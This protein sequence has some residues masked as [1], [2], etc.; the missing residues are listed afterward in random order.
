MTSTTLYKIGFMV[1]FCTLAPLVASAQPTPAPT[2]PFQPNGI[3]GCNQTSAY[4]MSVGT[5]SAIGGTYVPVNDA[6]V[7]LNTGY[8]VYKE[9]V[10]HG[11][12]NAQKKLALAELIA[13][14]T[15]AT[16]T[17]RNGNPLYMQDQR[18][19]PRDARIFLRR[20]AQ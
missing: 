11:I 17:G 1:A 7:T 8:L 2:P 3:L 18:K 5:L 20:H 6:S 12:L 10:L 9:C 19:E 16:Q 14:N 4:A 15:R 13:A